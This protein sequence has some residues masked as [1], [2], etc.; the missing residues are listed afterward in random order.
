MKSYN[1]AQPEK[2]LSIIDPKERFFS[3]KQ[4]Q[5][6]PGY[7]DISFNVIKHCFGSLYKPLLPEAALHR[8]SQGSSENMQ[9]IY[10]RTHMPKCDFN[11]VAKQ[12]Y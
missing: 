8:C 11:K 7:D 3:L 2:P 9:Q 6:P 4:N 12:L 5:F 1:S 10:R